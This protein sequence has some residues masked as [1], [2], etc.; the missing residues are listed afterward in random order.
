MEVLDIDFLLRK[1]NETLLNNNPFINSV[2]VWDKKNNKYKNLF[3]TILK[4]RRANYDKVINIQRFGASGLLTFLSKS[5]HKIGFKKNPFSFSYDVKVPH[6]FVEG[7]HEVD[8]N[9]MLLDSFCN[10]KLRKPK[11][12][13]SKIDDQFVLKYTHIYNKIHLTEIHIYKF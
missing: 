5:K 11:L 8:R 3:K 1:G 9:L 2:I 10:I 4:V 6:Q 12:Y 13:P 7:V